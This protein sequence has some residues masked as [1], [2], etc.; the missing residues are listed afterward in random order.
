MNE[1]RRQRFRRMKALTPALTR[2]RRFGCGQVDFAGG[3]DWQ[4]SELVGS[5]VGKT[6]VVKTN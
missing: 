6:A 2:L 5:S 4:V 3:L 1:A